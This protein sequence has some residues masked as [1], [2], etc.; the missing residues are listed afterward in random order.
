M[1]NNNFAYVLHKQCNNEIF[2]IYLP[3][4]LGH[5]LVKLFG[6]YLTPLVYNAAFLLAHDKDVQH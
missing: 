5:L 1:K 2:F 3:V 6:V 4:L